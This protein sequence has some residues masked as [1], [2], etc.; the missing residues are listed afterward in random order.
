MSD[1]PVNGNVEM[2]RIRKAFQLAFWGIVIMS[3]LVI[4]VFLLDITKEKATAVIT[5]IQPFL[6]LLGT[7]VGAFFGLQIG[8]AGKEKAEEKAEKEQQ[9]VEKLVGSISKND[10][11]E[12]L[13]KYKAIFD[14]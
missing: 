4:V 3:V 13:T 5:L 7:L 6:T 11:D 8:Q 1:H 10:Y 9:K 14:K 12:I 2:L